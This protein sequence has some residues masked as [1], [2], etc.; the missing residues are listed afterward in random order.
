M[1]NHVGRVRNGSQIC[2]E[3][4]EGEERGY[5]LSDDYPIILTTTIFK[6]THDITQLRTGYRIDEHCR[7]LLHQ[8]KQYTNML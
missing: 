8:E 2:Q 7:F 5:K 1:K 6:A 3:L 4:S